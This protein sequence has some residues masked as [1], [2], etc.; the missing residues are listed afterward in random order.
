[1]PSVNQELDPMEQ[2]VEEKAGKEIAAG[3]ATA[4]GNQIATGR[5]A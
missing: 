5:K 3:S 1:M 2:A 4:G